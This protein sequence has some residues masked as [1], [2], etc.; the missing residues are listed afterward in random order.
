MK[1]TYNVSF[2]KRNMFISQMKERTWEQGFLTGA[3]HTISSD[4]TTRNPSLLL[5]ALGL[6]RCKYSVSG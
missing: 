4:A 6:I 1:E 2:L 3:S 5:L